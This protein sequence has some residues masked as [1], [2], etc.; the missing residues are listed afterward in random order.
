MFSMKRIILFSISFMLL[1]AFLY[2]IYF[3]VTANDNELMVLLLNPGLMCLLPFAINTEKKFA[4][5]AFVLV[6]IIL[7]II[8]NNWSLAVGNKELI[9][10]TQ[11]G[12]FLCFLGVVCENKPLVLKVSFLFSGGLV[13]ILSSAG[14]IRQFYWES[15]FHAANIC[16]AEDGVGHGMS[17]TN[18]VYLAAQ[19][20]DNGQIIP[21]Y[22][23]NGKEDLFHADEYVTVGY[24]SQQGIPLVYLNGGMKK[25]TIY[26]LCYSRLQVFNSDKAVSCKP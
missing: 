1:W 10:F 14:I 7:T 6:S 2:F 26:A 8:F 4:R 22:P 17:S 3:F 19:R 21:S 13:L 15:Q 25:E 24:G 16:I 12:L 9:F 23:I 11:L 5:W 18:N 20:C